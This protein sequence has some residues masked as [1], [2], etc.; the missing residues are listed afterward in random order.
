M[1]QGTGGYFALAFSL[2]STVG[3]SYRVKFEVHVFYNVIQLCFADELPVAAH[4][5]REA[6]LVATRAFLPLRFD[7]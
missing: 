2:G 4:S 5:R 3:S 7:A 1:L 6:L